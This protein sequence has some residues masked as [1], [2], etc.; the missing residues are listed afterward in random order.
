MRHLALIPARK[1][2]SGLPGKNMLPIGGMSL[3]ERAIRTAQQSACFDEVVVSSDWDEALKLGEKFG[4]RA[5]K[6]PDSLAGSE[7]PV[8]ATVRHAIDWYGENIGDFGFDSV[9]V[10]NPTSPFRAVEDLHL[11]Y[12]LFDSLHPQ[13]VTSVHEIKPILMS[14]VRKGRRLLYHEAQFQWRNRQRR[15]PLLAQ[16]GALYIVSVPYF[17][18]TGKLVGEKGLIHMMPKERSMDID[19][20]WDYIAALAWHDE[21]EKVKGKTPRAPEARY[22]VEPVP[23]ETVE[24]AEPGAVLPGGRPGSG[25]GQE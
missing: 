2:S 17:R 19:D 14:R 9:A 21:L 6:R 13:S 15:K 5:V 8:E 11:S 4:C 1:G 22:N 10:L 16:N 7:S 20:Y 23:T 3:V 12:K 24:N 25:G 18:E